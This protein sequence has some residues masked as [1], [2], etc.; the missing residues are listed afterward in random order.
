MNPVLPER[1][2]IAARQSHLARLQAFAVGDALIAARPGLEVEYQ[3]K[4]SLGDKNLADPLWK[5]PERGVFTEDFVQDLLT[6]TADLVVHS[7]KDLPTEARP[8]L[9]LVGTLPRA[10]LRDVLLFRPESV[11]RSSLTLLTSSP[12]RTFSASEHLSRLLPFPVEKIETRTVRGN[13][14]TRVRKLVEGAEGA[15]GLF[16]AKAALDRLLS[17]TRPEFREAQAELRGYL[18]QLRWMALPLSLFPAAAAQGALA[19]EARADRH[20]L[21]ALV[22]LV[23]CADTASA[24]NQE[25]ERFAG[26]G[27]GCH[28]KIGLSVQEHPR[29]GRVEFFFGNHKG[30]TMRHILASGAPTARPGESR[31]PKEPAQALFARSE[32][33]CANP[34]GDL[35]VA[36]ANALPNDWKLGPDQLVWTAGVESWRR[37]A[38]RGVWVNGTADGLGEGMPESDALAGRPGRWTKLTHDRGRADGPISTMATYRLVPRDFD[39]PLVDDYFWMSASAFRRALEIRP[40][41]R[42]RRHSSGPGHT[43]GLIEK[44]LGKPVA[45]YINYRHWNDGDPCVAL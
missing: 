27:G 23:H 32:L 16:M 24:V 30:E 28:Q 40:E 18:A 7:W 15:D 1:V 6:G 33:V 9:A 42:D 20:D 21:A 41:I 25:R 45:V 17:S 22:K 12:R 8:G 5:M 38:E 10:D 11:G 34:G 2:R 3:F 44:V 4:E 36:R 35:F 26:F 29:L 43:P 37:L 19:I 39:L 31:W 14:I 13:V